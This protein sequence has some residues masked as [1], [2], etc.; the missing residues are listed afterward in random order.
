M[1]VMKLNYDMEIFNQQNIELML[2]KLGLNTNNYL[3][4]MTKP[5]Y[6]SVAAIDKFAEFANRYCVI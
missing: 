4:T 3:I 1:N 5:S 2:S 6:L